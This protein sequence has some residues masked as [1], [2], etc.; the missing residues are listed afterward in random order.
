[1]DKKKK[2]WT[3]G[4]GIAVVV[5]VA[6][7]AGFFA[8][9][10]QPSF[11]NAVCHSPMDPYNATYDQALGQ[12]GVD[13][14]GNTVEDTSSMLSVVHGRLVGKTCLDCHVPTIGEQLSEGGAWLTG[15]YYVPL[16]ERTTADLTAARDI[17][18][19]SFCLN[20]NCHNMTRD[21]L[22]QATS[23][24]KVNPTSPNTVRS[25]HAPI[26]IRRTVHRSTPAPN[27]MR[28]HRCRVDG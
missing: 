8:W 23:T 9:H 10:E 14:W 15:N 27:V 3:I 20:K 24:W 11:C 5:L 21:D 7:G 2:K 12:V 16:A 19:D 22:A 1:M 18:A 17:D 28:M 4:I 6:A 13:K 26:A 25:S